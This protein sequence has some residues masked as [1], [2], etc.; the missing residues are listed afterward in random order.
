MRRF[1]TNGSRERHATPRGHATV[2]RPPHV[3]ALEVAGERT[4]ANARL[5]ERGFPK[6]DLPD[7]EKITVITIRRSILAFRSM[8]STR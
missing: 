4:G 6:V 3:A 5:G 7:A 1:G 8:G 2:P